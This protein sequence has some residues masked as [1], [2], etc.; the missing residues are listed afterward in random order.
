MILL[1]IFF[2]PTAAI[3]P[4]CGV[5]QQQRSGRGGLHPEDGRAQL[6]DGRAVRLE[7]PL[8]E[9]AALATKDTATFWR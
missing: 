2:S 3:C 9:A 8:P 7:R 5:W 1:V 4:Q 6:G